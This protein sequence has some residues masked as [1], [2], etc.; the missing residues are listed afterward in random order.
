MTE[1]APTEKSIF[2]QAVEL[3]A[4]ERATFLEQACGADH[5]LRRR[6]EMLLQLHEQTGDLLDIPDRAAQLDHLLPERPGT[7]IGPYRLLE[8]LGSGGMGVVFLAE[9]TMPVQR[10]VALKIIRPGM[11]TERVIARFEAERQALAVM[12]HPHVAK[13]LDAGATESGR[14]YFVM[15]LVHGQSITRYC[16]EHTLSV[17]ERLELF[18]PVCEHPCCRVRRTPRSQGN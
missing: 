7:H 3:P 13:V 17:R 2:L 18:I 14:P 15:E 8:K 11:D 6:V 10:Q 12:D 16:D 4:E 1:Y 5:A 9:Q